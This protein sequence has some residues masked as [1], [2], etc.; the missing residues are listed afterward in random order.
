VIYLPVHILAFHRNAFLPLANK[1]FYP[2][3]TRRGT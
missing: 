3:E 1:G 2:A